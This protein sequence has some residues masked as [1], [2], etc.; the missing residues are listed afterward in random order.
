MK[1]KNPIPDAPAAF[2]CDHCSR[3][4][5]PEAGGTR[6]RNHCPHCLWSVHL[7]IQPG[8]RRCGCRGEME[9]IAVWIRRGGEWAIIHRC[10]S[11]STLR[12]NRIAGDDSDVVLMSLAVRPLAMPPFPLDQLGR[13]GG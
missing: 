8:D 6:H 10:R 12:S 1:Q 13:T 11:C 7:D 5:V 3:T 4:V 9:P 2:I